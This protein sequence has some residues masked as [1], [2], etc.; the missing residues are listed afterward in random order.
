MIISASRRT[1]IPA[2]Y[3]EWFMNRVGAGVVAVPN[4]MNRKQVS[5][6]SLRPSDVEAIVF[7]T[8]DA[9]PLL[10]HLEELDECGYRYY[11]QYT[12]TG[13]PRALEP[14]TPSCQEAVKTMRMLSARLGRGRVVWRYDP[15]IFSADL[16]ETY[17]LSTLERLGEALE[18]ASER[19][20]VSFV[21]LYRKARTNLARA[22]TGGLGPISDAPVHM[23]LNEFAS[24]VAE[25]GRAHG[26]Q[27]Q[28]CAEA[29]DLSGTGI[30]PGRCVDSALLEQ[31][32]GRPFG[33]RKDTGQ[34]EACGCVQSR[35]IGMYDSCLHGCVY[36]YANSSDARALGNRRRL[37]DPISP[38]LLGSTDPQ[39]TPRE[40]RAG[41]AGATFGQQLSFTDQP[42]SQS[43]S[44]D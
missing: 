40:I 37:H 34:R 41:G 2:F 39:S 31:L 17:H 12:L 9:R 13:Y 8:K 20:V 21:D 11:F 25:I 29:V 35:D 23:A 7:W 43:A 38:C 44:A 6:I 3:S 1:D 5:W 26:F 36:C 24:Q 27:V 14:G 30:A 19:L 42:E 15:I 10:P 18:G 4:P 22:T 28:S 16:D 32:F 33:H